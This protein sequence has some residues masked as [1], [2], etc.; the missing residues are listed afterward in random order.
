[1]RLLRGAVLI[2][3]IS[4]SA[5]SIHLNQSSTALLLLVTVVLQ[6]LDSTFAEAAVVC[7]MAVLFLDYF[8]TEPLFSF[9][10]SGPLDIVTLISLFLVSLI[11]TRIQSQR[12]AAAE[13]AAIQRANM[14]SLY[15]VSH[16][17]LARTAPDISSDDGVKPFLSAHGVTAVCIYDAETFETY[18]AGASHGE[19]ASKTRDSYILGKNAVHQESGIV[20][21]CLRARDRVL[22]AIGFEGLQNPEMTAPALAALA[23]AALERAHA[24][25]SAAKAAAHAE[26][27]TLRSALLDA[28][29]HEF[30]TPLATILA[31][32]GGLRVSG[33][34]PAGQ[35]ELAELIETEAAR[36][37]DLTSRLLRL[38]RLDR[39]ELQ[40]RLEPTYASELA[41]RSVRRY[42]RLWPDRQISLR[43][44]GEPGTVNADPELAGLAISQLVENACRYSSRDAAVQVAVQSVDGL[45]AITVRNDGGPIA[46]H[47][48]KHIFERFYRGQEARRNT[49]GSGLGLYVTRKIA[50]AHGGD[51]V[52]AENGPDHVAFC[53]TIP[54]S[55]SEDPDVQ[56]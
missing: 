42:A 13:H 40:P 37:T 35:A 55:K 31:A 49:P 11:V 52:L 45:A 8:F 18:H 21:Q 28:L 20:V 16:E 33:A 36:L 9:Y 14:E 41:A 50:I 26:A 54:L 17:L 29:A 24:F 39:E 19:L 46:Q 25:R 4:A 27:E 2:G 38:A 1:V 3:G 32:A 53:L 10:V 48:S 47:E 7:A 5:Y 34:A 12:R 51:V 43:E 56:L 6:S 22:G 15:K 30:K 44:Q 23:V